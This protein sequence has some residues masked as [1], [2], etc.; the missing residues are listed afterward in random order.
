MVAMKAI[1]T[2]ANGFVGSHLVDR[3][4]R[5]GLRVVCLVRPSADLRWLGDLPVEICA[6]GLD[7]R[8]D[9]AAA[10][11]GADYVFHVAGLTRGRT[12]DQY[13]AANAEPTGRLVEAATRSAKS[14]RR[15]VYVSSLAAAGPN[16]GEAPLDETSPPEPADDYGR[17]KLAA[18]RIVMEAGGRMP[19]AIVRPPGVYGPRDTN[20]LPLFRAAR[21]LGIV[22][23]IGGGAIEVSLVHVADL[24]EGIWL[25]ASSPA[26]VGGTYF[27]ASGTYTMADFAAAMAS[28]M[29][30][31]VRLVNV[32]RFLA[33]LAGELGEIRRALTGRPGIVSRRKVRD[34]LQP[35]WTCSWEKARRE[36][37]YRE[38]IGLADGV[39]QTA[40]WYAAQGWI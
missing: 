7:S 38:R 26:G 36:I 22:P 8:D 39:R 25:A 15:F 31:R 17:S 29:E 18:E 32:P 23:A 33:V 11:S 4:T 30:R 13:M 40:A 10:V 19:V 27:I 3:L 2:G 35:R 34:L 28:A 20:F 24:A 6:C 5:E 9:L 14:I 21:R 1:V 37:G 16:G 12:A